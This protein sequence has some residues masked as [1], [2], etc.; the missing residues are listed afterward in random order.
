MKS[1]PSPIRPALNRA[2]NSIVVMP[3]CC[4][5]ALSSAMTSSRLS[6]GSTGSFI[7]ARSAGICDGPPFLYLI[8]IFA[9]TTVPQPDD[10]SACEERKE[11]SSIHIQERIQ[12]Q[13]R[14][15]KLAF[16]LRL[17]EIQRHLNFFGSGGASH[18]QTVSQINLLAQVGL[19]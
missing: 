7:A 9:I 14:Q 6:W 18:D 12:I 5:K 11:A 3:Y 10:T 13:Q 2:K 17:Q 16:R 4:S 19:C 15:R 1:R 8:L